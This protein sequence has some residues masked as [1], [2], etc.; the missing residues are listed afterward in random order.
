MKIL[1]ISQY[2]QPENGVPQR[3]WKWLS[4]VL[5]DTGHE[6]VA[7]APPPHYKRKVSM[8]EWLLAEGLSFRFKVEEEPSGV[9]IFRSGFF[10][11]GPSLTQR[12][13]N[14]AWISMAMI[15]GLVLRAGPVRDY[16]PDVIIGTVPALPT[17]LVTW[18]ASRRLQAPYVIDLRDAWPALFEESAK[19]NQ[20]TGHPSLREKLLTKGPFQLLVATTKRVVNFALE[21]ADG[22]VTTSSY[23]EEQLKQSARVPTAV[24]RNVFP[25]VLR[26]DQKRQSSVKGQLN[27]LYAGTLGR[28]QRLDNVIEAAKIAQNQLG[29][30]LAIRF[31]G[32]GDSW[33]NLNSRAQELSAPIQFEHQKPPEELTADLDWADTALVHLTDW[34]SLEAAIPSK[35]Y[36]LMSNGI[37]ICAVVSGEAAEIV[38]RFQAGHVVKPNDP[39][40]LAQLWVDL[41]QNPKL[42]EVPQSGAKWV[43]HEREVAA[44]AAFL[45]LLETVY[46]NNTR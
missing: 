19:W 7:I 4:D 31:V 6:V 38:N 34:H 39:V 9:R 27:V 23:L 37:H 33:H 3:R 22:I 42:L 10:P 15:V 18:F 25:S 17:A 26:S 43:A 5:V 13:W 45:K 2:W 12:I 29:L 11:S 28:A 21:K 41:S 36:E 46:E 44:P 1:I 40:G 35:T 20:A 30:D 24:V 32:D 8:R 16:R 14:Q